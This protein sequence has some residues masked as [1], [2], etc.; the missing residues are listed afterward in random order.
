MK[1]II[2]LG[3][4]HG[5]VQKNYNTCFLIEN[6]KER[7]LVDT[8]GSIKIM[9][10]LKE[11]GYTL[12]DINH[13]FISHCH[14]DHLLGLCWIFKLNCL[15][16]H[17]ITVYSNKE[18]YEAIKNLIK[19]LYPETI[20][21]MIYDDFTFIILEE[22]KEYNIAGLNITFFDCLAK[23]NSLYGFDLK[24]ENNK[25]LI[26]LGD[27]TCN[28]KLYKRLENKEYVMH[29]AFCLDNDNSYPDIVKEHHATVKK[30]CET[31]KPLNIKNLILYHTED[32]HKNK[33]ELYEQEG[34]KYFNNNVIVPI[35]LEEIIL[36]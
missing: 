29:E 8:G 36:R 5:S 31:L 20:Q 35:D 16:H 18:V 7:L 3:T 27:E 6:K 14:T 34:E 1:K 19:S 26:F 10:N 15:N 22:D 4:G 24:L 17:K 12:N 25:S 28:P 32:S 33:K 30:V 23:E 2:M 21:K 13:I 11:A 9:T